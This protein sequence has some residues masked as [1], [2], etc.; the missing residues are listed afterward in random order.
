MLGADRSD[1]VFNTIILRDSHQIW[2]AS[3]S[4][5]HYGISVCSSPYS[6]RSERLLRY[7]RDC[8]VRAFD[9]LRPI[10]PIDF[11]VLA[12]LRRQLR[13]IDRPNIPRAMT[14]ILE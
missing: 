14:P 8:C 11:K 12:E 4:P 5:A 9:G 1:S 3:R 7:A 13:R 6:S 10:R 2:L